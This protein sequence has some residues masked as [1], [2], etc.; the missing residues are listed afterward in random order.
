M[1]TFAWG[2]YSSLFVDQT[3]KVLIVGLE[4]SG[5]TTL[6]EQLKCVYATNNSA[7]SQAGLDADSS[8]PTPAPVNVMK[9]KRI[10]PTVGLNMNRITHRVIPVCL[11]TSP[12]QGSLSRNNGGDAQASTSTNTLSSSALLSAFTPV[13]T[14]LMLWDVGGSMQKLWAN[15]FASC[16]GVIFVVDSTL[17]SS[18]AATGNTVNA[19]ASSSASAVAATEFSEQP[20]TSSEQS[21]VSSL[22]TGNFSPIFSF[23]GMVTS[24]VAAPLVE[25]GRT[26]A[27]APQQMEEKR[28]SFQRDAY[29]RNAA[30]LR[31]LF[32]HPLLTNA[33]LLILSNKADAVGHCS[34]AEVQEALGLVELALMQELY[35]K[36][37]ANGMFHSAGTADDADVFFGSVPVGDHSFSGVDAVGTSGIGNKVMRL[38]EVSALDGSGVRE[39]LDWLVFQMRDSAREVVENDN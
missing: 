7:A 33:P 35:D 38:A 26:E 28:R 19:S 15:Y 14:R 36:G 24:L 18:A 31:A 39:A 23:G 1:F 21:C 4:S 17:G 25:S 16:H 30:V 11:S 29:A 13:T 34:L 20:A 27:L 22:D 8:I 3:Y 6:L 10:R 37:G 5:K 9:A 2:L 12:R 32:R